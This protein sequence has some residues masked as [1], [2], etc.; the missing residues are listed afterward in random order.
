VA[1]V[2]A[3]VKLLASLHHPNVL[4]L[5]GISVSPQNTVHIVTEYCSNGTLEALVLK[6]SHCRV[7]LPGLEKARTLRLPAA[8]HWQ[9]R[10]GW[11]RITR[12]K[13]LMKL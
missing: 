1:C 4:H 7:P 5:Y 12:G 10:A 11:K 8:S 13:S 6:A 9:P 2:A 3:E